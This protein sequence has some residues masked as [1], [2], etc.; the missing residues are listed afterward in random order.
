MKKLFTFILTIVI[1]PVIIPAQ[2]L[3]DSGKITSNVEITSIPDSVWIRI[4][5]KPDSMITSFEISLSSG[6]NLIEAFKD[7][8]EPLQHT[9]EISTVR[10]L[11]LNFILKTS[12]P[13]K[14][15]ADMI[16]LEYKTDLPIL[17][18]KQAERL[19][20]RYMNLAESFAIIPLGQGVLAKIILGNDNSGANAFIIAG[21][22]LTAGSYLL[23]KYL[24]A[25]KL[26]NIRERNEEIVELNY[27][28]K[29]HNKSV[30]NQIKMKNDE[31]ANKWVSDNKGRG[32]VEEI[33]K[34]Q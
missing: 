34:Q 10:N 11:S 5:E 23:G 4:D 32:I 22:S 13:L 28:A 8:Y 9:L 17:D 30:R 15:D 19:K 21:V 31:I 25:R 27:Q 16:G 24:S 3:P 29:E 7:G 18:E 12:R 1:F 2:N 20:K 14:F 33:E 6:E 26:K